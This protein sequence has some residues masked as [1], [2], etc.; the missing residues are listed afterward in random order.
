MARE[1][2]L[3]PIPPPLRGV[4]TGTFTHHSVAVRLPGIGR[5]ILAENAAV[6]PLAVRH[7][8]TRLVEEIPNGLISFFEDPNAPDEGEWQAAIAPYAGLSWLEVPWFF[9]ETYFYRRLLAI[10]GY[11]KPGPGQGYDPY[12][13]EKQAGLSAF[14]LSARSLASQVA[15]GL[16]DGWNPAHFVE[17]LKADLWANQ[18]DLSLWPTASDQKPDHTNLAQAQSHLLVDD[19]QAIVGRLGGSG[20]QDLVAILADNAGAELVTDLFLADYL[21]STD[22]AHRVVFHLKP[23][24]TFVSD[25]VP[26]DVEST[27]QAMAADAHPALQASGV[28]LAGYLAAG[29]LRLEADYFWTSPWPAWEMPLSLHSALAGARVVFSKGDANY[30]RLL[31]DRHWPFTLPFPEVV[32]YFPTA[33]AALRTCKSEIVVGLTAAQLAAQPQADLAWL[34]NGRWGLI[35]VFCP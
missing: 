35:Q 31:G 12:Q 21:L 5:R 26:N 34:T 1:H 2:L 17:L 25:A 3:T 19:S 13:A 24:P 10:T 14:W 32:G 4:E 29:R 33:L 11:F 16:A 22:C 6:F 28:R 27:V 7:D 8:L 20:S 15:H 9:A 23:H 18:A 30:R